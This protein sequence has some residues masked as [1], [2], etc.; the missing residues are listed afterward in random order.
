M[1]GG[2]EGGRDG[3]DGWMD[4]RMEGIKFGLLGTREIRHCPE[5]KYCTGIR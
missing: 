5:T 3:M 1:E 4:G 2:R